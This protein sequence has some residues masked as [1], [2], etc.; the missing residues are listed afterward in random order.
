M[1]QEIYNKKSKSYFSN[2]RQDI[3]ETIKDKKNATVLEVGAGL[4]N[5]LICLKQKGIAS[6]IH[7]H[8][9]VD[10]VA[11]KSIFDSVIIGDVEQQEFS[12]N[13]YDI[14]IFADVLEHLIDPKKVIEK[15][16]P[17]L[18]EGGTIVCSI[19]NVR[20]I[21]ALYKIY[22][23]GSFKY[24]AHGLFDKT[25]YRFFCKSDMKELL[26]FPGKLKLK[27]VISTNKYVNTKASLLDKLTFGFF[28]EFLTTQYILI[29]E[30]TRT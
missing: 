22:I 2:V 8:D 5:T 10:M 16:I 12:A 9:I 4:G 19:P 7:L 14:V 27:S 11:D 29:A 26:N 3:I 25:H 20:H 30:E 21:K 13:K 15:I 6:S 17:S 28:S 18:K 24:D 1:T 23:K